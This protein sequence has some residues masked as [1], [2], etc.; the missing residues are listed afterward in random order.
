MKRKTKIDSYMITRGVCS[1]DCTSGSKL[2]VNRSTSR[3]SKSKQ[4]LAIV[5]SWPSKSP[6]PPYSCEKEELTPSR[7]PKDEGAV[8]SRLDG[9]AMEKDTGEGVTDLVS[10]CSF[11]R[12][13][14]WLLARRVDAVDCLDNV[15]S[16]LSSGSFC[17]AVRLCRASRKTAILRSG[18]RNW[19]PILISSCRPVRKAENVRHKIQNFPEEKWIILHGVSL[20]W[21]W[22]ILWHRSN[23]SK[24]RPAR[25]VAAA[26]KTFHVGLVGLCIQYQSFIFIKMCWPFVF[27]INQTEKLIF[28]LLLLG[29][30]RY[31]IVLHRLFRQLLGNGVLS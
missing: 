2:S 9:R 26:W 5:R 13:D 6:R 28:L 20:G 7:W 21:S 17:F 3:F 8:D 31:P 30:R 25:R 18:T 12:W 14:S 29:I 27:W 4:K 19:L 15:L 24:M 23:A 1:G 16:W 22:W 10:L 11:C